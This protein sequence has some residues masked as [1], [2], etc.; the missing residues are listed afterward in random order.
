MGLDNEGVDALT[1]VIEAAETREELNTAVKALD[2]VLRAMHVW[3]PNWHNQ[4]HNIAFLDVYR[5][6]EQGLPPYAMGEVGW[7]WFDQERAAELKALG[8]Y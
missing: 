5:R 1:R 4:T 2:R 3:V 7:W 6:P 8:A